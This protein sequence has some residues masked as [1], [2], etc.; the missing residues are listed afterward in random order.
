MQHKD[1]EVV[2][3]MATYCRKYAAVN[4]RLPSVRHLAQEL[5]ISKS[6]AQ[7]YLAFAREQGLIPNQ[8]VVVRKGEH[9]PKLR[10]NIRCGAPEYQEE[11]IEEYVFLPDSLY[12]SGEKFILTASGDSMTGAGIEDGEVLIF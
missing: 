4:S 3:R 12:G 11:D 1:T 7:R 6:G 2:E 9:F 10:N 8:I 5:G